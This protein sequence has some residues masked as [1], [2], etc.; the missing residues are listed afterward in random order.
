MFD[1]PD[2]SEYAAFY[3]TYVDPMPDGDILDHL[4]RQAGETVTYLKT[5]TPVQCG[6][7]Y[8]PSKW[9]PRQMLGHLMDAERVFAFRALWFA[10]KDGAPLPGF[11]ENTWAETSNADQRTMSELLDEF[12]AVRTATLAMLH[13]LPP[14]N[15]TASGVASGK[16]TT[17]RALA[18][19]IAGHERHHMKILR[20]RYFPD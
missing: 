1:R 9:T 6:Y 18:W 7:R 5:L 4:V 10:R 12:H 13:G 11:D 14:G 20:D 19:V 15:D 2:H 3:R 8:E 17:V 16:P